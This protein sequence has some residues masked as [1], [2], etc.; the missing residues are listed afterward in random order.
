MNVAVLK[1]ELF[2]NQ[3]LFIWICLRAYLGRWAAPLKLPL[4]HCWWRERSLQV[5]RILWF[6]HREWSN[7]FPSM[8]VIAI[9]PLIPPM[10]SLSIWS[11]FPAVGVAVLVCLL[12][13][14]ATP[15]CSL[16][17]MPWSRKE[18]KL[19]ALTALVKLYI[20]IQYIRSKTWDLSLWNSSRWCQC[21]WLADPLLSSKVWEAAPCPTL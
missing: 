13:P 9:S 16:R 4:S 6:W 11:P 15:H 1:L 3:G 8:W 17:G 10:W 7:A 2:R 5:V 21:C 12:V 18:L 20:L 19:K 14:L